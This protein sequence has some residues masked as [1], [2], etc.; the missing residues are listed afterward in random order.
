V[1]AKDA[2][3]EE[4]HLAFLTAFLDRATSQFK[5][6]IVEIS[7]GSY[8]WLVSEPDHIIDLRSGKATK[9]SALK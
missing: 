4:A 7:W 1:I 6:A 2:G 8:V 3:F 5:K 9:L